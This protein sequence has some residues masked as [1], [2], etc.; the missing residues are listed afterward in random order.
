[1]IVAVID[2]RR[3]PRFIRNLV[4]TRGPVAEI[5]PVRQT[6]LESHLEWDQCRLSICCYETEG[7]HGVRAGAVKA[8]FARD[9]GAIKRLYFDYPTGRRIGIICKAL[10]L[11]RKVYRCVEPD[12]LEKISG[13]VHHGALWR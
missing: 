9:A 5:A 6:Q 8:L 1:V 10:A 3:H 13:T 4:R 12:E 11:A 2:A 7:T